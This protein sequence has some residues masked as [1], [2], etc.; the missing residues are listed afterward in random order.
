MKK[1]IKLISSVSLLGVM[2]LLVGGT[3]LISQNIDKESV[4]NDIPEGTGLVEEVEGL[5][6]ILLKILYNYIKGDFNTKYDIKIK[7]R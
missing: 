2:S 3:L 6:P 5:N 4:V 1:S 7:G